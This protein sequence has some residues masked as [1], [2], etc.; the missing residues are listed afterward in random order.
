MKHKKFS[1]KKEEEER[2][3]ETKCITAHLPFHLP[4]SAHLSS[5]WSS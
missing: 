3:G 5:D 4:P 2:L 1:R